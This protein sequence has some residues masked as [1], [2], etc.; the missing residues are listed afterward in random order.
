MEGARQ[1]FACRQSLAGKFKYVLL[2]VKLKVSA[3]KA[4]TDPT[5]EP[6]LEPTLE[7]VIITSDPVRRGRGGN[8]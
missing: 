5:I 3:S 2:I 7:L 6:T 8:V 4:A 1:I